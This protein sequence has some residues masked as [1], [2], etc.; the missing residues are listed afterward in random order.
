[1]ESSNQKNPK[2]QKT[3]PNLTKKPVPIPSTKSQPT[4][5]PK[6]TN[7]STQKTTKPSVT[8]STRNSDTTR[9]AQT[10]SKSTKITIPRQPMFN[11]PN[12]DPFA[13]PLS[14]ANGLSMQYNSRMLL[15]NVL[16][17]L[18]KIIDTYRMAEGY[19]INADCKKLH[20][21]LIADDI[22]MVKMFINQCNGAADEKTFNSLVCKTI[23]NDD[24]TIFQLTFREHFKPPKGTEQNAA[25]FKYLVNSF[26]RLVNRKAN[27][28]GMLPIHFIGFY[29]HVESLTLV[30]NK[31]IKISGINQ[32]TNENVGHYF[33]SQAANIFKN[34]ELFEKALYLFMISNVNF[35]LKNLKGQSPMDI[36]VGRQVSQNKSTQQ[37]Q[38]EEKKS[39]LEFSTRKVLRQYNAMK[40]GYLLHHEM[41]DPSPDK[42]YKLRNLSWEA[43][44]NIVKMLAS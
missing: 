11:P 7:T 13:G 39:D 21:A 35:N 16:T 38:A 19:Q 33:A 41:Q 4:Q 1:M 27:Y 29:P 5:Q 15:P 26:P 8:S 37:Q 6:T 2:T 28:N 25:I 20:S 10:T 17:E 31:K 9:S 44:L 40:I 14:M 43:R 23:D 30:L 12:I 3:V 18:N 22:E 42:C 36:L 32:K 34:K 24:N